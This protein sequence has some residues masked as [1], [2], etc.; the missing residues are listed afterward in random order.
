MG[1]SDREWM[2]A[3]GEERRRE[4][5][6][7]AAPRSGVG[8]RR[9]ILAGIAVIIPFGLGS[10]WYSHTLNL[11]SDRCASGNCEAPLAAVPV[12]PAV[13]PA[14][15]V[16]TPESRGGPH[17]LEE[18]LAGGTLIDEA[19]IRC[20][21]GGRLPRPSAERSAA[22][23]MVSAEY[24]ARFKAERAQ[25]RQPSRVPSGVNVESH[26]IK[27][28]SGGGA[29]LAQWKV[30]GNTIEGGSVCANH[31]HG[32]IDYREC[33]KGAKVY[34]REQCRAWAAEWGRSRAEH[35]YSLKQRYC[36]AES[37]FSPMG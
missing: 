35:A 29:Y 17:S 14:P 30:Q 32:S 8:L 36:T 11:A 10:A 3:E 18:C 26:S 2:R 24:L 20:R 22:Q 27:Q 31:R 34:F 6:A 15:A 12:Q 25:Q 28:W 37:S 7:R 19:V 23:G 33:R 5:M 16:T 13:V 1:V 21:N 4:G 9:G